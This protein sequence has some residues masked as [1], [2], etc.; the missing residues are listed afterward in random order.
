MLAAMRPLKESLYMA[1]IEEIVSKYQSLF[2]FE[3]GQ[4]GFRWLADMA[5]E[6]RACT[7]EAGRTDSQQ[8]QECN[9]VKS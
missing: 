7:I 2:H 9:A 5:E 6:I 8:P 1:R 3:D 4:V